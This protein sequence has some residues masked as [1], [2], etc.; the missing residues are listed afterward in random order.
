MND[1]YSIAYTPNGWIMHHGVLGMKWGVR[2]DR[3]GL[4]RRL[5]QTTTKEDI[6]IR[7]TLNAGAKASQSASN[8]ARSSAQRK[9]DKAKRKMDVSS[10]SDQELQREINRMS[11]ERTYK[12]LKTENV[13][14]GRDYA[15]SILQTAGDVLAIG[16]SAASIALAIHTIRGGGS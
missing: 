9:R 1:Y 13:S 2:H 16:A 8:I 11:L 15:S 4:G 14:S 12:Q 5:R 3:D 10:M 6:G 7:N